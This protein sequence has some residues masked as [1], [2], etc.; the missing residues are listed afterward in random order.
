MKKTILYFV[1]SVFSINLYSQE[2]SCN[3]T[4]ESTENLINCVES[5]FNFNNS[6]E[7]EKICNDI[8]NKIG[9]SEKNFRIL[10]CSYINNALAFIYK[11]ERL[12]VADQNY[13]NY[14]NNNNKTNDYWFYLFILSH[15]IGH[16]LN[17]HTLKKSISLVDSQKR[18][19][20]C[21]RFAGMILRKYN[22]TEYEITNI[23]K[24]L[25][26]PEDNNS[27]HPTFNSR[28]V[29]AL[30]G[31]HFENKEIEKTVDL[32]RKEIEKT[33]LF[34]E[35]LN[36]HR[37][38][39]NAVIDYLENYD[40]KDLQTAITYYEVVLKNYESKF[41]T[42]GLGVLYSFK[43]DYENS[44]KHF[45]RL[46]EITKN[47]S[48]LI[49]TYYC[50][51]KLNK[52]FNKDLSQI[53]YKSLQAIDEYV[54]LHI[55][56]YYKNNPEKCAEISEYAINKFNYINFNSNNQD[57][58]GYFNLHN[59]LT[60]LYLNYGLID[61]AS[62][63]SDKFLTALLKITNSSNLDEIILK[64]KDKNDYKSNEI[65]NSISDYLN[66]VSF[67]TSK[68]GKYEKSNMYLKKI[69]ENYP[70]CSMVIDFRYNYLLGE[71]FYFLKKY[72]DA[73]EN[74][75]KVIFSN[76]FLKD[77]AFLILGHIYKAKNDTVRSQIYYKEACDLGNNEGCLNLEKN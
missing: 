47:D 12:I 77:K 52:E 69:Q 62:I 29:A 39:N 27:T 43:K 40:T 6:I 55:Y 8:L 48:Y 5:N 3:L 36:Y 58:K 41:A 11:N 68:Q 71:N 46:Y 42:E 50:T 65:K 21:D 17:G 54:N 74:F 56:Y 51:L 64:Y 13:L 38:A 70:N 57:K 7:L 61:Y 20:E 59:N 19:L 9:I 1:V 16:H 31:Y 32:Y 24:K 10:S 30:E 14:L 35:V 25:P 37:K 33:A 75:K 72:E 67:I 34:F 23:L 15:E 66:N 44:K 22:A 2:F 63:Y 26:H 49:K 73:L 4:N 53:D 45:N 76:S 18:E 28:V 60:S